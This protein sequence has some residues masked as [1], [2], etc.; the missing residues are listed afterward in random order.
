MDEVLPPRKNKFWRSLTLLVLLLAGLLAMK[1]LLFI[2]SVS[3]SPSVD[4]N[5]LSPQEANCY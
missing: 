1:G 3:H 4:N 2:S 5:E